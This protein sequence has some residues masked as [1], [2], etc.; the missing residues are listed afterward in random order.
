MKKYCLHPTTFLGAEKQKYY[1]T[2]E[3]IRLLHALP[4]EDCRPYD[5][6]QDWTG[7][8]HM[9]ATPQDLK[10]IFPDDFK[11]YEKEKDDE[12]YGFDD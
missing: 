1:V 8:T 5:P 3:D 4:I 6:R 7:W 10:K 12:F 11:E 2:A 9:K